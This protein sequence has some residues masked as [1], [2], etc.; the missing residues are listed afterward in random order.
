[1]EKISRRC[2]LHYSALLAAL[3]ATTPIRAAVFSETEG[4]VNFNNAIFYIPGYRPNRLLYQGTP[5]AFH[6]KFTEGI[7]NNYDGPRTMVSRFKWGG[8][9]HRKVFPLKGHQI[10]V[11]RQSPVAFFNSIDHSVMVS[12]DRESLKLDRLIQSHSDKFVGGGHAIFSNDGCCLINL[13][14]REMRPFQGSIENHY[15]AVVIRDSI[16]MKVLTVYSC[17]GINP[18]EIRMVDDHTVAVSNYGSTGWPL[19]RQLKA[20]TFV[21][22]PSIT[23]INIRDGSLVAKFI[24]PDK[25]LELRHLALDSRGDLLAIQTR[26]MEAKDERNYDNHSTQVYEADDTVDYRL[27]FGPA[28]LLSV[29]GGRV[30]NISLPEPI[31]QRQ[32]QSIVYDSLYDQF[33]VTYTSSHRIV[34][35]D[36]LN[37]E[38]KYVIKTRQYGVYYPRGIQL[39]PDNRHYAVSGSWRN[40]KIFKRGSHQSMEGKESIRYETFLGHSHMSVA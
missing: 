35:V 27:W 19:D 20:Y 10:T 36:A 8:K 7:T 13:E 3:T 39:L 29:S 1:M 2:L 5:L 25:E 9:V 40:I 16:S 34:V 22:E 32:G 38:A 28:P 18:H 37:F 24:C 33:I 23:L 30:S 12:F 17:Y 4:G 21:V 14:R 31:S 15:G 26:L 11:Q 6:P